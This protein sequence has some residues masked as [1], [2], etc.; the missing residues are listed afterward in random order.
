MRIVFVAWQGSE[1]TRRWAG[2][3]AEHGHDVHVVTCGD[4][5]AATGTASSTYAVHDLGDPR[6][7]K[8]GY[9][10]KIPR[11]RRLIRSLAP[12]VVHAHHAT[13]YGLLAATAG[14]R[15]LAVTCH[16]SDVL[17]SGRKRV[18]RRLLKWVFDRADVVTAPAEHVGEAVRAVGTRTEVVVFQYGVEVER[19]RAVGAAVR[20]AR[21]GDPQ[22]VRLATARGLDAI[23]NTDDV[24]RAVALLRER[25]VDC[26]FEVAGR[27]SEEEALRRL[28]QELDVADRVIFHGH[29]PEPT[30]EALIAAADVFVSVAD[31]DGVSIALFEAMALGPVP[32]LSDI[33]ANRLWVHDGENGILVEI[34]PSAIADGILRAL[35]LD[36]EDVRRRNLELVRERG[37][38]ETNLAA[39]EAL[40]ERLVRRAAGSN[41]A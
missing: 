13:S 17:V 15:P 3:F 29:V 7:G 20:E 30:A 1:H 8:P 21:D 5:P 6:F 28:V 23:Y 33:Q 26:V 38:R 31:S 11:A 25:G 12:D 24:A 2:F 9:L 36:R 4:A 18:M 37:D 19:L 14:V 35:E 34:D 16:G 40:L 39:C 32:L 27:G 22:V 10:L 41:A